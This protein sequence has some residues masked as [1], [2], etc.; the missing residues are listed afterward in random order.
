M[1]GT[2]D[3]PFLMWSEWKQDCS[4]VMPHGTVYLPYVRLCGQFTAH[5]ARVVKKIEQMF[6]VPF[7]PSFTPLLDTPPPKAKNI[8]FSKKI[9]W[10]IEGN[11]RN[12][13]TSCSEGHPTCD[14]LV[15]GLRY[16]STSDLSCW[17]W[18]VRKDTK[19]EDRTIVN[20]FH[21]V[22][23]SVEARRN[24]SGKTDRS[25]W[26]ILELQQRPHVWRRSKY[27]L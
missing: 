26:K 21:G 9:G 4:A 19:K 3:R 14:T 7:R 13:F 22:S 16:I 27:T 24:V 25:T 23:S 2:T 5:T 20:H 10:K 11:T 8:F 1:G 15:K 12:V 17:W 18:S 6:F